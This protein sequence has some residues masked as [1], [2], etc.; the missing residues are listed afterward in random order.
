MRRLWVGALP[1]TAATS[2]AAV[3]FTGLFGITDPERFDAPRAWQG[4]QPEGTL[5]VPI[6][7]TETGE[8]SALDLKDASQ[9]GIGPHGLCIGTAGSGRSEL[10]RTLI[11]GLAVT[12]S[13]DELNFL[14]IDHEGTAAFDGLRNLP[15]ASGL[16][17]GLSR[18]PTHV[19][20]M[21]DAISGELSG[22]RSCSAPLVAMPRSAPTTGHVRP[23]HHW[24]PFPPC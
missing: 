19:K 15:H 18:D 7:L 9:G 11:L 10:L 22:V 4:R 13:P 14:L 24:S 1:D 5:R 23:G 2:R 8:P 17:T 20:R 3:E 6:G 16:I 12:H 21:M